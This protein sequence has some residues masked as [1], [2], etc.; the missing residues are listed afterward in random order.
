M[1]DIMRR[2]IAE[3]LKNAGFESSN[4]DALELFLKI[5]DDR[6]MS[7][8][9]NISRLSLHAGRPSTTLVDLFGMKNTIQKIGTDVIF[10]DWMLNE[11]NTNILDSK[12]LSLKTLFSSIPCK[13]IEYPREIPEFDPEWISPISQRVEKFIHI[14]EFM[15]NFPPNHTFR[16]TPLKGSTFKNQSTKVKNRLEQSLRSEGNMVKL[17]KSSGSMPKFI[18]YI[19][20]GK[21]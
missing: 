2:I 21:I 16:I 8:L 4:C 20:K 12:Y 18:N 1:D 13:R 6:I 17:I 10:E 15:P 9:K 11:C 7:F 3:I 19:Y 14:Y 5:H